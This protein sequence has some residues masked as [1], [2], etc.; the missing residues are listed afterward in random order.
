MVDWSAPTPEE[1]NKRLFYEGIWGLLLGIGLALQ[2]GGDRA[3][4]WMWFGLGALLTTMFYASTFAAPVQRFNTRT[5]E[6]GTGGGIVII[7]TIIAVIWGASRF[8]DPQTFVVMSFV[9]GGCSIFVAA[10][11]LRLTKRFSSRKNQEPA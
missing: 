2:V 11:A 6:I 8:F 3:I 7:A 10:P 4:S 1:S 9:L 5:K